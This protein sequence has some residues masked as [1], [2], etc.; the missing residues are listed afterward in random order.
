MVRIALISLLFVATAPACAG[1]QPEPAEPDN[2]HSV[3]HI[4]LL[5][6]RGEVGKPFHGELTWQDNYITEPEIE[7][8]GLPPGLHFDVAKRTVVG[9][10]TQ[11]GFF[12]V[13]VA[14]RKQIDHGNFHRPKVDE[15]WWPAEI[16]VEIYK[17]MKD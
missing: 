14:I 10:P 9:T 13:N 1:T 5:T 6:T 7:I 2:G 4:E 12:T 17:P 16:E 8:S 15:R 3:D 11:A